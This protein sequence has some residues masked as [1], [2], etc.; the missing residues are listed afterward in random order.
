MDQVL[1]KED[2]EGRSPMSEPARKRMTYEDLYSI[3]ENMTGQIINGELVVTP[4]PSRKHGYSTTALGAAVAAPYQLGQG[5]GPGGW[6]IIIEPEIGLGENIMVPDLAGWKE[7]R[8]PEEEPHNWISVVPDWICE[9]LSPSTIR[10]DKVRKMPIYAQ[11]G[12]PY[13]WLIDP[14]AKTLDV[15][16]LASAQWLLLGTYVED[17][18]VQAEPFSEIEIN[19]SDLWREGRRKQATQAA[20]E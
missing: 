11:H 3:P 1:P 16:R 20:K 7:E 6:V 17:D 9:V 2:S 10:V 13:F 4:R 14:A 18:K 12:V 19:L 8:Y 15:F 5:G